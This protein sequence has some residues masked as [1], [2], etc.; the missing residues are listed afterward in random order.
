M[1]DQKNATSAA[2]TLES[3]QEQK[4]KLELQTE[5]ASLQRQL[6]QADTER[7]W[8]GIPFAAN[9]NPAG[10]YMEGYGDIVDRNEWR[11]DTPGWY[12][13][14]G[15]LYG[16]RMTS[17]DDRLHGA[18]PPHWETEADL[19]E[20]RG[21]G[22]WLAGQD[23]TSIGVLDDLTN[24]VLGGEGFQYEAASRKRGETPDP[25]V[26]EIQDFLDDLFELNGWREFEREYFQRSKRD[27]E[28]IARIRPSTL[29]V[30]RF[31]E[32]D[33]IRQ[34]LD[35]SWA[36]N[37][38]GLDYADWWYGV[39]T[40]I[41]DT[42]TVH[43]YWAQWTGDGR[44]CDFFPTTHVEFCKLNADRNVKRGM[45]DF[46]APFKE[47]E[48]AAKLANNTAYGAAV[49]ATIAYI[50]EYGTGATKADIE[51]SVAARA[52]RTTQEPTPNGSQTVHYEHYRPG[53]VLNV[54]NAKY[55]AGP[56]GQSSA[57]VYIDVIQ[58]ILR[59]V[60]RR[61][62]MPEFMVSG[63]AS[64]ANYASTM[65]SESPF[66]KGCE[67]QQAFYEEKFLSLIWKAIRIA[68]DYGRFRMFASFRDMKRAVKIDVTKPTV[69]AKNKLEENQINE[70]LQRDKIISKKTRANRAGVDYE[71][72]AEQIAKEPQ[73][74]PSNPFLTGG[75]AGLPGAP[76][77]RLAPNAVDAAMRTAL[78]SCETVEEAKSLVRD[79]WRGYP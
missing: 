71:V 56:M 21:I 79:G 32:P 33:A 49:Q 24:Y 9:G 53:R 26:Q 34:P 38:A 31:T 12:G 48:A 2:T 63:D 68:Y 30:F 15:G 40:D 4:A 19:A 61:W 23:E 46:Y 73:E 6:D 11:Y 10:S 65:V 17:I 64:N 50:R 60:G 20:I 3:L 76:P 39:A 43:G 45:S 77:P 5:I 42:E 62:S 67:A 1:S 14:G 8:V 41:G 22:R 7:R 59:R 74:A 36:C 54:T 66:V 57:P 72:E 28:G 47:I 51:G 69:E 58:M 75:G 13:G 29:P 27:G 18:N 35:V 70:S 37:Y 25:I 44:D 52:S 16:R 55:H 78:E